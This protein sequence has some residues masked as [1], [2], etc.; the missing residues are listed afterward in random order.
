MTIYTVCWKEVTDDYCTPYNRKMFID[1]EDAD[2]FLQDLL[3]YDDLHTF[4]IIE[5]KVFEQYS[6][7]NYIMES[8]WECSQG[9]LH[10][11]DDV[12]NCDEYIDDYPCDI[13]NKF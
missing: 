6:P 1:V 9:T 12:C 13:I 2:R 7:I 3:R 8:D 11:H 5:E 10:G 4:H